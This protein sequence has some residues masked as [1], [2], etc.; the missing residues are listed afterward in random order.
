MEKQKKKQKKLTGGI[1]DREE[2]V[3]TVLR[4][5][6]WA[7]ETYRRQSVVEPKAKLEASMHSILHGLSA[8]L[9]ASVIIVDE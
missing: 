1:S 4:E 9:R 3:D 8:W 7:G 5:A 6:G 2:G